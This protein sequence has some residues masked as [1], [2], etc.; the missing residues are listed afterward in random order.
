MGIVISISAWSCGYEI[1]AFN[2]TQKAISDLLGWG[3]LSEVLIATCTALFPLG[4]IFGAII[5]GW[6]GT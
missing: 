4:G 5:G 3:D 6:M 2:P 1:A